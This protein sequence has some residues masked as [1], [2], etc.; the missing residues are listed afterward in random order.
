M[1]QAR[2]SNHAAA[3]GVSQAARRHKTHP[4]EHGIPPQLK[5]TLISLGSH[6]SPEEFS[7]LVHA[8]GWSIS[9]ISELIRQAEFLLDASEFD[10]DELRKAFLFRIPDVGQEVLAGWPTDLTAARLPY[11][12]MLEGIDDLWHPGIRLH[13][14]TLPCDSKAFPATFPDRADGRRAGLFTSMYCGNSEPRTKRI[15]EGIEVFEGQGWGWRKVEDYWEV[16][17]IRP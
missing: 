16:I 8:L 17:R 9:K 13:P 5:E 15:S 2:W 4:E 3:S 12:A 6:G 1:E 10:M 11:R 14:F 7:E